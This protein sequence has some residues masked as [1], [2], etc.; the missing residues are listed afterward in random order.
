MVERVALAFARRG[1]AAAQAATPSKGSPEAT[2]L[3]ELVV[4]AERRNTNLQKAPIA[5]SVLN[6]NDLLKNGVLTVDQLQFVRPR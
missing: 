3:P 4:T 5:A 1:G 2:T 6:Q